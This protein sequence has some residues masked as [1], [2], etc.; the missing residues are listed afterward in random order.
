MLTRS[1]P[2]GAFDRKFPTDAEAEAWLV[3]CRWGDTIRCA[4]CDSTNVATIANR[5]PAPY[6]CRDC[7]RHFSVTTNTPMHA[8]K[9]GARTWLLAMYLI[10]A[11]PKGISSI[12]LAADLGI[13]QKSA[14]HLGHR[15]REL[16]ADDGLGDFAGPV[17]V[18]ETYVGGLAK[19]MH[20]VERRRRITGN[21][22]VDKTPVVG[23]LDRASGQVHM[24]IPAGTDG[25][26]LRRIVTDRTRRGAAIFT[27]DARV[28]ASLP[29]Q[30]AV[31]HT[32]GEY[33][34]G[35]VH[36]NGI[37]SLWAILKRSYIGVHHYMSPKHL[38]RYVGEHAF[39]HNHR[40]QPLIDRLAAAAAR[41]N[42][43]RLPWATLTA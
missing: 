6:R 26:T 28:Y 11:H 29:Y 10:L 18:D 4:H 16:L 5:R 13:T 14:W 21:H 19:N 31:R 20:A 12:Q 33:V 34:R 24:E 23:V 7:R 30:Q 27:D 36:T 38:H 43:R 39:R 25:P 40:D 22:G 8:S 42:G 41:M 9:L 15:V 37:E 17:E 3:H 35:R 1:M 2:R 32:R